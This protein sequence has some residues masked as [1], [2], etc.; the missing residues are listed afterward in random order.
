MSLWHLYVLG[1]GETLH[2][3][4]FSVLD[5]LKVKGK[6]NKALS[7]NIKRNLTS[8]SIEQMQKKKEK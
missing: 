7:N 4:Q 8:L 1:M 5:S 3:N 6:Q 2:R